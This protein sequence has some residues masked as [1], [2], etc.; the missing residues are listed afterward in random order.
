MSKKIDIKE[1]LV[2]LPSLALS[3]GEINI[4]DYATGYTTL[5]VEII[6][7]FVFN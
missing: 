4:I 6:K 3:T 1:D 5:A 7:R 2:G